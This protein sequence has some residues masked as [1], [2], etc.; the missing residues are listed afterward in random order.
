MSV[1]VRQR[2]LV[3]DNASIGLPVAVDRTC[4]GIQS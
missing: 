4:I 2:L 3:L 1:E